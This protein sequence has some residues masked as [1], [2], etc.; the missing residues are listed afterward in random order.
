VQER[1]CYTCRG[2]CS[3]VIS[4]QLKRGKGTME[5]GTLQATLRGP[6]ARLACGTAGRTSS[7]RSTAMS[8]TSRSKTDVVQG[9]FGHA[10]VASV[11]SNANCASQSNRSAPGTSKVH[12]VGG[13]QTAEHQVVQSSPQQARH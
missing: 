13:T 7:S 9:T 8:G 3:A 2:Y 6:R 10:L 4:R 12:A 5:M 11:P 1:L